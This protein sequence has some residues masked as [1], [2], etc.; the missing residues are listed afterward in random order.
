M[1]N[2]G[3]DTQ[4]LAPVALAAKET[5][6]VDTLEADA[7][8]G[9]YDKAQIKACEEAGVTPYVAVPDKEAPQRNS[10]R[11]ERSMFS[12]DAKTDTYICPAEQ[13]LTRKGQQKK[14][15]KINHKSVSDA[16]VCAQCEKREQCLTEKATDKPLYRWEHEEVI[17][18]HKAR[19]KEQGRERMS[20][21]AATAEPPFGT[22]KE[23]MGW[24]SV[25]LRG[26]D[27][28][29]AEMNRLMLSYN[30]KRVLNIIGIEAFK[31]H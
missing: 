16:N 25:L 2:D 3:N 29:R 6:G 11:F 23:A 22:L 30:F 26:L 19:M 8:A 13:I 20:T 21:R 28:V 18:A 31:I 17:D 5:R 10:G 14:N 24:R 9:D 27:K 12:Y 15:N 4:P 1:V 7:D